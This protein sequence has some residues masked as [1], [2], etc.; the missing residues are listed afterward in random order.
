M[1]ITILRQVSE[2]HEGK[3]QFEVEQDGVRAYMT[4]REILSIMRGARS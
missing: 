3:V 4:I 1:P 2:T